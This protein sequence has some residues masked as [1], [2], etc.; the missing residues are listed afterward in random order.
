MFKKMITLAAIATAGFI[1]SSSIA[2][3]HSNNGYHHK[4]QQNHH[5]A[6]KHYGHKKVYLG[7]GIPLPAIRHKLQNRGFYKIRFTDRYLPVYKA[8]ACKYGK[9]FNLGINRWGKV[10]WRNKVGYC[11]NHHYKKYYYNKKHY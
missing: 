7:H 10:M 1:A 5:Y 3:A 11:G 2:S 4:H 8:R 9:K 6:P